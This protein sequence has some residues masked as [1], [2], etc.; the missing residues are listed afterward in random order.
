MKGD[1]SWV[2]VGFWVEGGR[3]GYLIAESRLVWRIV[4]AGDDYNQLGQCL[5]G[6][7]RD[8]GG[9]QRVF[10]YCLPWDL[11]EREERE[12]E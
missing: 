3:G 4:R 5:S 7:R 10:L 12:R 8:Y 6:G 1:V 2:E 9:W 11:E